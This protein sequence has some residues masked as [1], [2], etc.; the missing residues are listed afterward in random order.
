MAVSPT[1]ARLTEF[2]MFP[3]ILSLA[4]AGLGGTAG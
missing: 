2:V 1:T 3:P 4:C